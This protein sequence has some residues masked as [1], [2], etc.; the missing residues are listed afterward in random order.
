LAGQYNPLTRH[1]RFQAVCLIAVVGLEDP[2][3]KGGK[4][5]ERETE[6]ERERE[7]AE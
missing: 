5:R 2:E 3:D 4:E 6:K 7:R 1:L